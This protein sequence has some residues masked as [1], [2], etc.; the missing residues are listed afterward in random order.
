MKNNTE[1]EL[2]FHEAMIDLYE[3]SKSELH[4]NAIRF[5]Q[6]VNEHGGVKAAKILLAD[7]N[8]TEGL[9]KM[10]EK[11]RL[12]LTMEAM[13]VENPKWHCLFTKEELSIAK[14][15]LINLDYKQKE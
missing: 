10:W 8:Y 4:Y 9:I 11:G 6:V 7:K 12:D 1:L 3:Q 15:K 2:Q 13:I 14:E 5:L